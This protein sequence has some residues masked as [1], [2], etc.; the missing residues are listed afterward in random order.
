MT[1]GVVYYEFQVLSID[2]GAPQ[3]GFALKDGLELSD[4]HLGV[5]CGH[6]N[7]SWAFDGARHAKLFPGKKAKWPCKWAIV[8]VIGLAANVDV[9]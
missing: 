1:S 3:I 5:E 6:N 7:T 4:P 2:G 9:S 8:D